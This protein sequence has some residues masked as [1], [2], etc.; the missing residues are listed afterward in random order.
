MREID[1]ISRCS[2]KNIVEFVGYYTDIGVHIVTEYMAGGDLH[3]YLQ[4]PRNKPTIGD[5]FNYCI[6]ICEGMEYLTK[7]HIIHRDLAA[8]NCML[9]EEKQIV[10]IS[11]FGLCRISNVDYEYISENQYQKLPFR[12]TAIE[13]LGT[14][15]KFSE[16]SDVWS[17][18]V[19]IWEIFARNLQPYGDL[20]LKGV[21]EFLQNGMRLEIPHDQ[22]CP[23][24]LYQNVMIRCWDESP[25]NRPTFSHLRIEIERILWELSRKSRDYLSTEYETPISAMGSLKADKDSPVTTP[26]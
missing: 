10:K 13:C 24:V 8:R 22:C 26:V 4:D 16:K 6:Q 2:H 18:G 20:D 21:R 19:V 5:A 12:W 7:Q 25:S 15:G 9:D 11:D 14:N 23:D 3:N 1:L 17:F